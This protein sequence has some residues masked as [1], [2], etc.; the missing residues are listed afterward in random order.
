[1][2]IMVMRVT[3][4]VH[5]GESRVSINNNITTTTITFRNSISN[6]NSDQA[7]SAPRSSRRWRASTGSWRSAIQKMKTLICVYIYIYTYT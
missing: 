7:R 5:V 6:S 4:E 1:M 3:G 2:V